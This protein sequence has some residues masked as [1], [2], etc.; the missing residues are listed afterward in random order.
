MNFIE[1]DNLPVYQLQ[2]ELEKLLSSDTVHFYED[3][4]GTAQICLN[5]VAGQEDD[6]HFGR[7]SL[8]WDWDKSYVSDSGEVVAP[9]KET[10]YEESDF[11]KLCSQFKNTLF[12]DVYVELDKKYHLGRTRIMKS[13]PRTCLSWHTDYTPRIHFP[14]QTHEGCFM[15]IDNEI[16]HLEQE[17][18]YYTNT[19]VPH[20]AFNSSS[21][22]RTHLVATII[23]ER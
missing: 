18:W 21:S 15:V 14:M 7:G 17:K 3:K 13:K 6:Y 2:N 22:P 5:S 11:N 8:Y 10:V 1:L 20:T 16:K 12:E 4:G 9:V 23:G 19:T